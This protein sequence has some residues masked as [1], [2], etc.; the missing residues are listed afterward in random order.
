MLK[1]TQLVGGK[2]RTLTQIRCFP[3]SLHHDGAPAQ[4]RPA[5][6]KRL[7]GGRWTG[8][9]PWN[10]QWPGFR[11]G[12]WEPALGPGAQGHACRCC[13]RQ[14]RGTAAAGLEALRAPQRPRPDI[15]LWTLPA[16]GPHT[17][18]FRWP[19]HNHLHFPEQLS[20]G[21]WGEGELDPGPLHWAGTAG[22]GTG[23]SAV[24]IPLT[25]QV[26][27]PDAALLSHLS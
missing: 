20:P 15:V 27:A 22:K 6:S 11:R 5:A 8:A 18:Y 9:V 24:N 3:P 4:W 1:A 23:H 17:G 25:E 7:S 14:R 16:P 13:S 12:P 19:G 2:V 21:S 10:N 26:L